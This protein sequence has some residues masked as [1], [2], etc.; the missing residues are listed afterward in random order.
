MSISN[1]DLNSL[2]L[3]QIT[4]LLS[5]HIEQDYLVTFEF[6]ISDSLSEA[7][8]ILTVKLPRRAA[9]SL[10]LT[11]SAP[12]HI[13]NRTHEME[14]CV[15]KVSQVRIINRKKI[16]DETNYFPTPSIGF[17]NLINLLLFLF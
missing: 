14:E 5:S 8:G 6:D 13:N 9:K 10:G 1:I 4:S 11:V 15:A 7:Y 3:N 17:K 12:R 16:L 2:N